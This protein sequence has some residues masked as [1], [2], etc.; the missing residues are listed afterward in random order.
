MKIHDECI[1]IQIRSDDDLTTRQP[2]RDLPRFMFTTKMFF[3]QNLLFFL[4]N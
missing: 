4:R 1:T 2:S 3:Y